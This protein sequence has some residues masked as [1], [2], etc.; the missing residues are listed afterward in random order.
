MM[1][2]EPPT[3]YVPAEAVEDVRSCCSS[4]S[5]STAAGRSCELRGVEPRA[6]D[7][8]VARARRRRRSPRRTRSRRSAILVWERRNKLKE[9]YHGLPGDKIRDLRLVGRRR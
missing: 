2:M 1:K 4:C 3:I 8:A 7:R 9:E 5:G 6:G